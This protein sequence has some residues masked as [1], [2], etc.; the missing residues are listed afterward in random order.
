MASQWPSNAPMMPSRPTNGAAIRMQMTP[1]MAAKPRMVRI[2]VRVRKAAPMLWD[3][4][5]PARADRKP[6]MPAVTNGT[7]TRRERLRYFC[8]LSCGKSFIST[9]AVRPEI[10]AQQSKAGTTSWPASFSEVPGCPASSSSE[11]VPSQS[12]IP[13]PRMGTQLNRAHSAAKS[14]RKR[15]ALR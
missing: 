5:R 10:M 14:E 3:S 6:A 15:T 2:A 8:W 1:S 13:R 4:V 9:K 7:M 11:A 12:A